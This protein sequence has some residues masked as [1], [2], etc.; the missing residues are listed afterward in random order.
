MGS[1]T[2]VVPGPSRSA[3]ADSAAIASGVRSRVSVPGV[4]S[5]ATQVRGIVP[6]TISTS[7]VR[8]EVMM[9][10]P[11]TVEERCVERPERRVESPAEGAIKDPL[12]WNERVAVEPGIP[13]PPRAEPPGAVAGP[14]NVVA[15]GVNV[16]FRE[17]RGTHAAPAIQLARFVCVLVKALRLRGILVECE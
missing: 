15:R 16:R 8:V 9:E 1:S 17:V 10:V 4:I 6:F 13:I 11:F 5:A 7:A 12:A 2:S 3:A 14:G